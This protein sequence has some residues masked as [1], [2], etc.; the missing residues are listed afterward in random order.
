MENFEPMSQTIEE[1]QQEAFEA[2]GGGAPGEPNDQ[3]REY[4]SARKGAAA[5][6][7]RQRSGTGGAWQGPG[8]RPIGPRKQGSFVSER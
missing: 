2:D 5:P 6:W 8:P 1:L 7:P 4:M 3:R